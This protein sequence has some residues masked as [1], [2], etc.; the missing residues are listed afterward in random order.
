MLD[1]QENH[2][3]EATEHTNLLHNRGQN[4]YPTL[5][6]PDVLEVEE[7]PQEKHLKSD[8]QQFF[9]KVLGIVAA[10]MLV[11]LGFAV[12]GSSNEKFGSWCAQLWV[13]ILQ[14]L[15][16][17]YV[18]CVLLSSNEKRTKVPGNYLL[19]AVFTL[20]EALSIAAFTINYEPLSVLLAIG[21]FAAVFACEFLLSLFLPKDAN[22]MVKFLMVGTAITVVL[23]IVALCVLLSF[24]LLPNGVYV[25][26]A[27]LGVCGA[28][29]FILLDL[30]VL[31]SEVL[32]YD[33]YIL[34]ALNLYLDTVRIFIFLLILLGSRRSRR[35]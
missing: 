6:P 34:G 20:L 10:Q 28:A 18:T 25:F 7:S 17:L 16:F 13:Q 31:Q 26:Y 1:R 32:D 11:T 35:R 9:Q 24:G 3:E 23:N 14:F 8:R 5:V 22:F 21:I 29:I 27:A 12:L 2:D 4:P 19:L 15:A 33:D 30:I